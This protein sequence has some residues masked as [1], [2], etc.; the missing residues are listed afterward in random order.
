MK[1]QFTPHGK[2]M[3]SYTFAA[4]CADRDSELLHASCLLPHHPAAHCI[5]ARACLPALTGLPPPTLPPAEA[6]SK[7]DGG[8]EPEAAGAAQQQQEQ[9]QQQRGAA[10]P[11]AAAALPARAPRTAAG[12]RQQ[13][14][15]Q[16]QQDSATVPRM[17]VPSFKQKA[18]MEAEADKQLKAASR[19]TAQQEQRATEA[20]HAKRAA[21]ATGLVTGK[22]STSFEVT[23]GTDGEL[24]VVQ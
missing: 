16:Q 15:Q 17:P 14:Q 21:A 22:Y 2:S 10:E 5:A 7:H 23:P 9:Q 3:H 13:Q 4:Q 8:T 1:R 12:P 6:R 24:L 18:L 19:A 20:A 11:E